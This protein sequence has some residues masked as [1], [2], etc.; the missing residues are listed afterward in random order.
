MQVFHQQLDV[1]IQ[2]PGEGSLTLTYQ[3]C[4]EQGLCYPPQTLVL[5]KPVTEG[6]E[7]PVGSSDSFSDDSND[8]DDDE[9][10]SSS[11]DGGSSGGRASATSAKAAPRLMVGDTC[12]VPLV[13]DDE[14]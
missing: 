9:P 2:H 10:S 8:S 3:G 5:G 12:R 14:S 13:M 4:S 6:S 1:Q 7:S 11:E